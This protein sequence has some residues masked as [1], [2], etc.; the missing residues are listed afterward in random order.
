M[1][2]PSQADSMPANVPHKSPEKLVRAVNSQP[3]L[4][5]HCVNRQLDVAEMQ[6]A[7]V[8]RATLDYDSIARWDAV[9]GSAMTARVELIARFLERNMYVKSVRTFGR[10]VSRAEQNGRYAVIQPELRP[11]QAV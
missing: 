7:R 3:T 1:A 5:H 9:V 2:Y 4:T 10:F 8:F 6:H 11:F